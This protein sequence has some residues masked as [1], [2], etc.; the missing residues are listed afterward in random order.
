MKFNVQNVYK[1]W[2]AIEERGADFSRWTNGNA[3]PASNCL[4][5]LQGTSGASTAPQNCPGLISSNWT[6][7]I[8]LM[9]HL[10]SLHRE[11]QDFQQSSSLNLRLKGAEWWMVF[12][13]N[14]PS[15]WGNKFFLEGK[16]FPSFNKS[17][18]KHFWVVK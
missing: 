9:N 1:E 18:H 4:L 16:S 7:S 11:R 13:G 6:F 5:W 8:S 2:T 3:V 12:T 10:M 15:S 17:T 14:A